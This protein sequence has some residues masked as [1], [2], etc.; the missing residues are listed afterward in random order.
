M[1]SVMSVKSVVLGAALAFSVLA[2]GAQAATITFEGAPA[3][4]V[5]AAYVE[6]GFIYGE[7]EGGL[8]VN[9]YGNPGHDME[10]AQNSGGGVLQINRLGEPLF[11]FDALQYW[12]FD[13]RGTGSQT[14]MV[15][16]WRD[17]VSLGVDT[18]DLANSSSVNWVLFGATN[19][20][21]LK[22]DQLTIDLGANEYGWQAVDN[23]I[24]TGVSAVPEPATWAM[25]ITGFG[26]AGAMLRRRRE[27]GLVAA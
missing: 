5:D 9:I 6:D 25:M 2:S 13:T 15:T 11:T 14:L 7:A 23:I 18:F 27:Q 24:L 26:L 3:D 21:D 17:G 10:G 1:G 19:L 20:A 22:L 8:Y 12:A 16:G 4:Y